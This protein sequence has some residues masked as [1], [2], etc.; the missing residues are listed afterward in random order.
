MGI[1]PHGA[2]SGVGWVK[3]P[4]DSTPTPQLQLTHARPTPVCTAGRATPTAPSAAAAAP[5]ASL[6]R[7]VRSVSGRPRQDG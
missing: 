1:L 5:R 3:C 2:V 4:A 6:G 7:T